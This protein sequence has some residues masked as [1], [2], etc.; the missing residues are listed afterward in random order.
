M[1]V[2]AFI[3][4]FMVTA[5]CVAAPGKPE[6]EPTMGFEITV[7]SKPQQISEEHGESGNFPYSSENEEAMVNAYNKARE[8]MHGRKDVKFI[9][10]YPESSKWTDD[11]FRVEYKDGFY[12]DVTMDPACL[13]VIPKP[14]TIS[15]LRKNKERIQKDIF[16]MLKASGLEPHRA[17]GGGHIHLGAISAFGN[18]VKLFRN[19]L[20]DTANHTELASGALE[21]DAENATP[22]YKLNKNQRKA[23]KKLIDRADEKEFKTPIDLATAFVE[24]VLF[25]GKEAGAKKLMAQ[26]YLQLNVM[27]MADLDLSNI[28]PHATWAG[29]EAYVNFAEVTDETATAETRHLRAQMNADDVVWDAEMVMGRLNWLKKQ[30]MLKLSD[31]FMKGV[32]PKPKD[33]ANNFVTYLRQA[34]VNPVNYIRNIPQE[35]DAVRGWKQWRRAFHKKIGKCDML[36]KKASS[37]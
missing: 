25:E 31:D 35:G 14:M 16:D 4:V 15:E 20:V 11:Y 17:F 27:R 30:G 3:L 24:D 6:K 7:T 29:Y 9:R 2:F 37:K 33:A 26:R 22:L 36:F 32:T 21:N 19:F 5:L 13:E 1:Q 12:F 10:Y 18:D 23:F 28:D 8:L 34:G